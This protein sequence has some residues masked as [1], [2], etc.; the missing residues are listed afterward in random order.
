MKIAVNISDCMYHEREVPTGFLI[1]PH[2]N[3]QYIEAERTLDGMAAI[4]NCPEEQA[5][6]IV[7]V[8][9]Q[10]YHRNEWRFY[11]SKTGQNWK[12]V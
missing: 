7:A 10:K 4:L 5:R 8:I 12:R 2:L 1:A 3:G 11:E 6:A 9:R